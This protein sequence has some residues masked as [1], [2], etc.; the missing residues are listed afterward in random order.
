MTTGYAYQIKEYVY[1]LILSSSVLSGVF[2]GLTVASLNSGMGCHEGLWEP[3]NQVGIY[4][5]V[6]LGVA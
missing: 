1:A 5:D 6:G 3:V 4:R 2:T